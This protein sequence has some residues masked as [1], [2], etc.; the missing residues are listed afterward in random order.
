[1]VSI[2][3]LMLSF[4]R[5]EETEV[6]LASAQAAITALASSTAPAPPSAQWFGITASS[7]PAARARRRTSAISASV[8]SEKR[9]TA[10]T[11]GIP[12]LRAFSIVLRQ[13]GAALLEQFEV[14]FGIG[15][16]QRLSGHHL[17]TAAVHLQRADGG[18]QHH[19]VGSQTAV[20]GT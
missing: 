16:M 7:A 10:T 1:M 11:T 3:S 19:A 8:S 9:L 14:L 6:G 13:V 12:K 4:E 5:I 20:R 17:G 18:H 15:G 2:F